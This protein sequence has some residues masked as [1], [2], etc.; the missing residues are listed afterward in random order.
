MNRTQAKLDEAR[1]FL[2]ELERTYYEYAEDLEKLSRNNP[3][4]PVCQYYL[5]AFIS[6]ARSV[7][8]IMRSEY[9]EIEGWEEWYK[10][11]K[12]NSEEESLLKKMNDIRVRSEKRA[13]LRLASNIYWDGDSIKDSKDNSGEPLPTWRKK[14]NLSFE[15]ILKEGEE[16]NKPKIIEVEAELTAFFWSLEEFPDKDILEVCK[17]YFS[18]LERL[19]LKCRGRFAIPNEA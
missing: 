12:P 11:E 16:I 3:N 17:S 2:G 19:V 6:A 7:T 8:W 15:R 1:F 9:Q 14:Y 10:S 5:S 4:P 13:P 18:M